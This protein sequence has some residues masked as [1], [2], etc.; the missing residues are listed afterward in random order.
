MSFEKTIWE[1]IDLIHALDVNHPETRNQV[2][3]LVQR[4]HILLQKDNV[5]KAD[6]Y[7][8]LGYIGYHY[9]HLLN[10][11][12]DTIGYLTM[13]LQFDDQLA[14]S[15]LYL[16]YLFFDQHNWK[17]SLNAFNHINSTCFNSF[18]LELR[19]KITELI[20]CCKLQIDRQP[21]INSEAKIYLSQL[22]DAKNCNKPHPTELLRIISDAD[23]LDL[24]T[25][26]Q[27]LHELNVSYFTE[28]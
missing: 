7:C 8:A 20:V 17:K 18:I 27:F 19:L 1:D 24:G 22:R 23:Y 9:N 28:K 14:V 21:T 5:N 12:I 2:D 3:H 25:K 6:L 13:S 11:S 4:I 16:G 26:E 10:F 15:W